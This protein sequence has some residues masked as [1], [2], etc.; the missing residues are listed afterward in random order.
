MPPSEGRPSFYFNRTHLCGNTSLQPW[1]DEESDVGRCF[2]VLVLQ[3]PAHAILALVSAYALGVKFSQQM[4]RTRAQRIAIWT[5]IACCSLLCLSTLV[6][7]VLINV[8]PSM[9]EETEADYGLSD[10]IQAGAACIGWLFNLAY[11][12]YLL[13]SAHPCHRGPKLLTVSFVLCMIVEAVATRSFIMAKAG[14]WPPDP[15]EQLLIAFV[16]LKAVLYL[17]YAVSLLPKK[18]RYLTSNSNQWRAR[19]DGG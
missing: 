16:S 13:H 2:Q 1:I 18:T 6:T 17:L 14:S 3:T 11:L 5:R 15:Q 9:D 12:P 10:V 4:P 19:H 7:Y 8:L